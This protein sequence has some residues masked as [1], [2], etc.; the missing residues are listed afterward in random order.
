MAIAG[1]Q[2][3]LEF[4][5]DGTS[6]VDVSADGMGFTGFDTTNTRTSEAVPGAGPTRAKDTGHSSAE[7]SF[8]VY[9]NSVTRPLFFE[10]AGKRSFMRFS[11]E[12]S[13]TGS[14]FTVYQSFLDVTKTAAARGLLS[15][16]MSGPVAAAPTTGSHS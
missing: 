10:L 15:Y 5:L 2:A 6:W 4:S 14:P 1:S 11:P 16:E 7:V 13:R 12:G 8:S 9:D 3:V